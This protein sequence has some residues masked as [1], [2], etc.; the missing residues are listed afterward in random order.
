MSSAEE[1]SAGS[2]VPV[3]LHPGVVDL[4]GV[5]AYGELSAFERLAEDSRHAPTL[6]GRAALAAMAGAEMAHY[7]LIE[8]FL[9]ARGVSVQDAMGPF[10]APLDE[11]HRSTAPSSWLES[12]VKAYVGDGIAAD[13]YREISGM[14][15]VESGETVRL[16]LAE[17]GHSE[18]A[19][20][21]VSAACAADP[22]ITARLKLWGRRLLGEAVIQAQHVLARRDD[23]AELVITGSSDLAGIAALFRRLQN[24]HTRRMRSLGLG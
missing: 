23:L 9:D 1:S 16:V 18:F 3:A 4:M 12:L 7:E 24:Q 17:T 2:R 8:E 22:R 6:S 5:L 19:E 13:F 11:Y 15:D 14:L 21:E 20:R 10:V